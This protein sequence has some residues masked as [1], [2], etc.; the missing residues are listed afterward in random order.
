MRWHQKGGAVAPNGGGATL[1]TGID[2]KTLKNLAQFLHPSIESVPMFVFNRHSSEMKC[3][4]MTLSRQLINKAYHE[5]K[6]ETHFA[7]RVQISVT[8]QKV[9]CC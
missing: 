1:L 9:S 4:T 8:P 6:G 7:C 2:N 5:Y 3:N